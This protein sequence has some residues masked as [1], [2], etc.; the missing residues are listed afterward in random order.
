ME[1]TEE[2]VSELEGR[3]QKLPSTNTRGK[4]TETENEQSPRDLSDYN[5]RANHRVIIILEA[6]EKEGGDEKVLEA[7]MAEN[8]L[9]LARDVNI[10]R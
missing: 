9:K 2:R 8:F 4:Q 1:G 7:T 6:D 5:K 3:R 10:E